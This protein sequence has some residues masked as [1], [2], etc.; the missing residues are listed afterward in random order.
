[1]LAQR[2]R[3]RLSRRICNNGAEDTNWQKNPDVLEKPG[4]LREVR[5]Q[6]IQEYAKKQAKIGETTAPNTTPEC[7]QLSCVAAR[8]A[9]VPS[10]FGPP[11]HVPDK[12]DTAIKGAR[13]PHL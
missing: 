13:V 2:Q 10:R 7:G 6:K 3:R 4:Y 5:L 11:C 1:M 8:H 12:P 9:A